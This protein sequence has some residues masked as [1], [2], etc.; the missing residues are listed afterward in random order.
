MGPTLRLFLENRA[1]AVGSS[2]PRIACL[3]ATLLAPEE[4]VT[5]R[6]A[7][8]HAVWLQVAGTSGVLMEDGRWIGTE[9]PGRFIWA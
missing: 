1:H 9:I 8:S 7:F 5:Y 3:I 6:R 2:S 4:W